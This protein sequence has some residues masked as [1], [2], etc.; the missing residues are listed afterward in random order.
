MKFISDFY[1][2]DL[3][4]DMRR[5]NFRLAHILNF[6][7]ELKIEI[8]FKKNVLNEITFIDWANLF[9]QFREW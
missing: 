3:D 8:K 5:E 2:N 9:P 6:I 1:S 7:Q 4:F